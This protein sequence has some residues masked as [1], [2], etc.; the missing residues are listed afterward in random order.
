M[1]KILN[2]GIYIFGE[3]RTVGTYS[4]TVMDEN[5]TGVTRCYGT[6]KPVDGD[7]GF[8]PGCIFWLSTGGSTGSTMYI[9]ESTKASADFNAVSGGGGTL[10]NFSLDDA[11]ND[12]AT[13]SV[14][15][16][17]VTLTGTHAT[18]DTL[19]LTASGSGSVIDFAN[20]GSGMDIDGTSS[21]WSVSAAGASIFTLSVTTAAIVAYHAGSNGALTIDAKGSGAIG[22]GATST[23][24][25]TIT[26]A[27]TCASTVTIT[28]GADADAII[29]TA[30]DILVSDGHLIMVQP[31][32]EIS[33]GITATGNTTTNTISIVADGLT[34]GSAIYVDSNNGASFTG[35]GGYLKFYN[36]TTVDLSVGRYGTMTI[37]G[38]AA[39]TDSIMLTAGD[40][41]LTSGH[42]VQTAGDFT[43]TLGDALLTSGNLTMTAGNFLITAGNAT[44]TDG[45]LVLTDGTLTYKR[46][47]ETVT[48]INT[49]AASESGTV[50]FLNSATEFVTTLPA[51][52]AGLHYKF[53]VKAAPSGGNYTIVTNSSANVIVGNASSAED[54]AGSVDFEAT[55]CDTISFVADKA[56]F[57]DWVEVDC[58]GT[59]WYTTGICSVQDAITFTT[60]S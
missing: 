9:N 53:Y 56:V 41:T 57:G 1:S 14:D 42:I 26:P 52:A 7:A 32:N 55:G 28:G 3:K 60:A 40:L 27:L 50:Y 34:S 10:S 39:G 44:L 49:I 20:T 29:V 13:V 33:L 51:P 15:G 47:T 48:A 58:D 43:M 35:T 22:I 5:S 31:D 6:T 16:G 46:K 25:V 18:N 2:R 19:A 38:N 23:G 21:T 36:G 24:A 37:A 59:N 54:A 45:D 8:A 4:V 17:A 30:G 12:G 11:Y